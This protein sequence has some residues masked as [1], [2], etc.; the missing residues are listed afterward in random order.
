MTRLG[1]FLLPAAAPLLAV[2]VY[3]P[4]LGNGFVNLDDDLYIQGNPHQLRPLP[5]LVPWALTQ[6]YHSLWAPLY[7]LSLALDRALWG[8]NPFGFHLT[9][10]LLH[11]VNALLVARIVHRLAGQAGRSE[12]VDA[13]VP[14]FAAALF[15]LHPIQVESVAWV[16]SRKE[17]LYALFFL[18]SIE[19]YIDYAAGSARRQGASYRWAFA[20]FLLAL[21]SKP[22]ALTLPAVLIVLDVY[23]LRRFRS[24]SELLRRGLLEKVPFFV[25]A[26]VGSALAL[27]AVRVGGALMRDEFTYRTI[28]SRL[29][30]AIGAIGRY[31]R[32]TFI[33]LDLSPFY[34]GPAPGEP[35]DAAFAVGAAFVIGLSL[36]AIFLWRSLPALGASWVF[37]LVT[38]F[39]TLGIVASYGITT[40]AN[41]FLYL[42]LLGIILPVVGGAALLRRR[43]GAAAAC[44]VAAAVAACV[45]LAAV[46]VRDLGTWRNGVSLWKRVEELQPPGKKPPLFLLTNLGEAAAYAGDEEGAGAAFGRAVALYPLSPEGYYGRSVVLLKMG[47]ADRALSDIDQALRLQRYFAM[48][49]TQ[50]W[51]RD[52]MNRFQEQRRRILATRGPGGPE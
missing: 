1:R 36:A 31:L 29:V 23:P 10:L 7:W 46:T 48:A 28:D 27:R 21:M 19:R 14:L 30:V 50:E 13:F 4:A 52:T 8:L 44:V 24:A 34:P 15:A 11:A 3:L 42:P 43:S 39:P 51:F 47:L 45:V 5:E 22:M 18:F 41:R 6:T 25:L 20:G 16:A 26:A 32:N 35:L 9:S 37:F 12:R 17:V 2:L 49:Q 38:V 33:P 40:V